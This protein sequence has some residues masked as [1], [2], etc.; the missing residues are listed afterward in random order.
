MAVTQAA[1][2]EIDTVAPSRNE[3]HSLGGKARQFG[4][5]IIETAERRLASER[6][7]WILWGPV[8]FGAGIALYFSMLGEPPVFA[9]LFVGG[10]FALY[11]GLRWG[12]PVHRGVALVL[13]LT[14]AGFASAQMR[15]ALVDTPMLTSTLDGVPVS[16]TVIDI[17]HRVDSIRIVLA[18]VNLPEADSPPPLKKVRLRLTRYSPVPKVGDRVEIPAVLQ[19]P[20]GPAVPG[21]YDFAR[22]AFFEGISASG[23]A[24]GHAEIVSENNPGGLSQ[25]TERARQDARARITA[26]LDPAVAGFATAIL[27]GERGDLPPDAL[28]SIRNA[29]LAHLLAISGLHIGLLAGFAFFFIRG[30]LALIPYVALRL[31]TK[32]IAAVGAFIAALAYTVLV[33]APIPTQRALIMTGL[34]LLA[35]LLDR[36]ALSM[37]LVAFAAMTVMVLRPETL[38]GASFQM[39]FAA[40]IALIAGYEASRERWRALYAERGIGG[41]LVLYFAGILFTTAIAGAATAPFSWFHFQHIA[42]S[43]Q[44]ANLIAVPAMALWTMPWGILSY[45]LMPLGLELLALKPMGW[46]IELILWAARWAEAHPMAYRLSGAPNVAALV[47]LVGGGLWL[48]LWQ[49]PWRWLGAVP[50]ILAIFIP[51][52]E[53]APDILVSRDA[54]LI[55]ITD[56]D[57]VLTLSQQR[58]NRFVA[59]TWLRRQGQTAAESFPATGTL[60]EGALRCSKSGC[61]LER[62]GIV[63]AMPEDRRALAEDCLYADLVITS[64]WGP[65]NCAAQLI[66]RRYMADAG[67]L[68]IALRGEDVRITRSR[69][70]RGD[71]PWVAAP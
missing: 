59:D 68:A 60:W 17:Q 62:Q 32:K 19:S 34:V 29:G 9:G 22:A 7:R 6:S 47:M 15:T 61:V 24:I 13:C 56:P 33:G 55:G 3:T 51:R 54:R 48:C 41:R 20:P 11:A 8:P 36:Q 57:G 38:M 25:L 4:A 43:G 14:A 40:V 71:R 52:L 58:N 49:R 64:S 53:A 26:V 1:S 35:I 50:I 31:P 44:I 28:D 16:G 30:G 12:E 23:Y 67:P 42:L 45:L 65:R 27:T 5:W 2:D 46:G 69:D 21:G 18:D 63:I 10:L 66:D 39:S 37:R 70:Q